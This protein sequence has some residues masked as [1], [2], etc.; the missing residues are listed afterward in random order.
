MNK[1]TDKK[2]RFADEYLIDLNATQAAIRAKYSKKNAESI[3]SRLLKDEAINAYLKEKQKIL[4]E[5]TTVTTEW[6]IKE[7]VDTYERCRQKIMVFDEEGEPT[8]EWRFEAPSA[9]KCLELLG[10]HIGMFKE[11][12]EV[13]GKDGKPIE[14]DVTDVKSR[15]IEKLTKLAARR[16]NSLHNS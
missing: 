9:I 14:V 5:I 16:S 4:E 12:V 11:K 7:L 3:G 8:G 15:L 2:K 13:G 6:V 10:K 1:L